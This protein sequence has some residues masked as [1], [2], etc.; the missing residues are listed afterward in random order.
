MPIDDKPQVVII[1]EGYGGPRFAFSGLLRSV[2]YDAEIGMQG[3]QVDM[4]I[5]QDLTKGAPS[6]QAVDCAL[7]WAEEYFG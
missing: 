1:G 5:L 4:L 2:H 7:E 6:L 3:L